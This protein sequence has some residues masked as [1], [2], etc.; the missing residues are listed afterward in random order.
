MNLKVE[1]L[2]IGAI[3]VRQLWLEIGMV[4]LARQRCDEAI[5]GWGETQAMFVAFEMATTSHPVI[6][7]VDLEAF[8]NTCIKH[9]GFGQAAL[10]QMGPME[11]V[12]MT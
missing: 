10:G 1:P 8:V 2:V 12:A 6:A 4:L 11:P 5:K 7:S 9:G 3:V